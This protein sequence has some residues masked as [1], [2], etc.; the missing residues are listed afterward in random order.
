MELA[1]QASKLATFAHCSLE[2][3][4][5]GSLVDVSACTCRCGRRRNEKGGLPKH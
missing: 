5:H 1:Q 2:R 3:E 4:F